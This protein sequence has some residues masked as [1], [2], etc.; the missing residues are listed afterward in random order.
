MGTFRLLVHAGYLTGQV[1]QL[2]CDKGLERQ[3]IHNSGSQ[4]Y[5]TICA[6][7][8]VLEVEVQS[9]ITSVGVARSILNR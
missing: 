2:K 3:S 9:T 6:F 4:L 8:N 5:R 1:I 7:M